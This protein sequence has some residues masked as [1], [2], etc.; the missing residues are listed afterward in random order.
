MLIEGISVF[1]TIFGFIAP[2]VSK[3]FSKKYDFYFNLKRNQTC[4]CCV[5][6]NAEGKF[7]YRW[8]LE[9]IIPWGPGIPNKVIFE[10]LPFLS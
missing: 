3:H 7:K 2:D 6:L 8:N 5:R 4:F 1:H 10:N 9:E